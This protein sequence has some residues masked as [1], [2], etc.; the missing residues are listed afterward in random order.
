M[1]D[2][3]TDNHRADLKL[4]NLMLRVEDESVFTDYEEAEKSSPSQ[5][6]HVSQ[7]RKICASRPF[8]S[9]RNHAYGPPVLCDFGEA[10]IGIEHAHVD[11][12]PEIYKAPEVLME[13]GWTH[14][15]EIWNAAC[16][17][18]LFPISI[19]I[20][21][22]DLRS[23]GRWSRPSICS[24]GTMRKASTTTVVIC[25]RSYPYSEIL[26]R[27][28]SNGARTRGASSMRTVNPQADHIICTKAFQLT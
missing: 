18:C 14:S 13:T 2:E 8:R 10:R 3:P 16:L 9:P 11:I 27:N 4:S 12:Q 15:A 26:H 28:S 21:D 5:C 23:Y 7:D 22:A 24:T 17:V 1:Q 20:S 6:K 19:R 25:M